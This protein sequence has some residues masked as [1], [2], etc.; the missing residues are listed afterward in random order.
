LV[1]LDLLQEDGVHRAGMSAGNINSP[2]S[3]PRLA[4]LIMLARVNSILA[5]RTKDREV[6]TQFKTD[7]ALLERTYA[8]LQEGDDATRVS[9]A[10]SSPAVDGCGK[11]SGQRSTLAATDPQGCR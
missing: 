9:A 3:E 11:S 7:W 8:R 2:G 10:A 4:Y 1:C 6:M 5:S